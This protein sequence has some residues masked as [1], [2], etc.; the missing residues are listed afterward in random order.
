MSL[1]GNNNPCPDLITGQKC[2]IT[3]TGARYV[4]LFADPAQWDNTKA[5]EPLTIVLNEGNSYTSKT[6]VPVGVDISN[7]MYWALT[8]NYNAQVEA[9]RQE[10]KEVQENF[11][12]LVTEIG[13]TYVHVDN[14]MSQEVI[15][16]KLSSSDFII[17]DPGEYRFTLTT[18]DTG[19]LNPVSN[20]TIYFN[21]C[22]FVMEPNELQYNYLLFINGQKNIRIYG[23]AVFDG[24]K[25]NQITVLEWGHCMHVKQSENIEIS[26]MTLKN[27][28]GDGIHINTCRNVYF[29]DNICEYNR[30]QGITAG[31]GT[32][33]FI[34]NNVLRYTQGTAPEAAI[35][36]ESNYEGAKSF[37]ASYHIYNNIMYGNNGYDITIAPNMKFVE[38]MIS[39]N[40]MGSLRVSN[41]YADGGADININNNEFIRS[42]SSQTVPFIRFLNISQTFNVK[43]KYN[44]FEFESDMSGNN[45]YNR[46]LSIIPT[47]S[48]TVTYGLDLSYNKLYSATQSIYLVYVSQIATLSNI[49]IKNNEIDCNTL[50]YASFTDSTG[51]DFSID[52]DK[53][54]ANTPSITMQSDA[55]RYIVDEST[56][57]TTFI[58]PKVN[59]L[60]GHDITFVNN[61]TRAININNNNQPDLVVGLPSTHTYEAGTVIELSYIKSTN[62]YY[63]RRT[64]NPTTQG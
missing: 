31:V 48:E 58:L 13:E 39:N 12:N 10:V 46:F 57:V 52:Y 25:D 5:Y 29:H 33:I 59:A 18:E 38:A 62:K 28:T 9:Y 34:Y 27:G 32:N 40:I 6:F 16:Q 14:T 63:L 15:N 53:H 8:G 17:F 42:N 37:N 61:S 22:T 30:R 44:N 45:T 43:I 54:I 11:N 1:C 41:T 19:A 51:V 36:I 20:T 49:V 47:L 35:D 4:P 3:Y 50:N 26:G 60:L 21:N 2:G 55:S 64:F 24:N 7:E 23:S 56:A